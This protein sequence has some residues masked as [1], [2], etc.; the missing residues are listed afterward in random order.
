MCDI[1]TAIMIGTAV[2]GGVASNQQAKAQM[3]ANADMAQAQQNQIDAQAELES[4]QRSRAGA[5]ERAT[6]RV[7]AG[8]SGVAGNSPMMMLMDSLFQEGFD[9]SITEANRRNSIAASNA[10]L[11]A[12]NMDAAGKAQSGIETGLMI[13]GA[14]GDYHA[15]TVKAG[16]TPI[17]SNPWANP[18]LGGPKKL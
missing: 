2:M 1:T 7:S 17:Y 6:M 9:N 8:E 13:A 15:R 5:A 12:R 3:K 14:V 10:E 4:L 11:N 16:K 18:L